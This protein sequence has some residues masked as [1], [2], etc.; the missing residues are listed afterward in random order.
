MQKRQRGFAFWFR[1]SSAQKKK[2]DK[3][4]G[5]EPEGA[6]PHPL[7]LQK[8]SEKGLFTPEKMLLGPLGS[9]LGTLK[10]ASHPDP[11]LPRRGVA[12]RQLR[13]GHWSA[14]GPGCPCPPQAALLP[15]ASGGRQGACASH[16]CW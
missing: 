3:G 8:L 11:R 12:G 1:M 2:A 10:G 14:T 5:G 15:C 13:T 6:F 16:S 4:G 9:R 7:Q